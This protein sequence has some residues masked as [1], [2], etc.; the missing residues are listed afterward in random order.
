MTI[1]VGAAPNEIV[2]AAAQQ[3]T[4]LTGRAPAV[5][6]TADHEIYL[7]D[8]DVFVAALASSR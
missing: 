7:N 6:D 8:P 3:L 1:A 4:E 2:A 5:V